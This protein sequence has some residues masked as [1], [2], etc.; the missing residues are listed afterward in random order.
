MLVVNLV[1]SAKAH[2]RVRQTIRMMK[3]AIATKPNIPPIMEAASCWLP[4]KE[5]YQQIIIL[6]KFVMILYYH[7]KF[8]GNCKINDVRLRLEQPAMIATSESVFSL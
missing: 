3:I 1:I 5:E 2:F 7:D 8:Y 4:G 6:L